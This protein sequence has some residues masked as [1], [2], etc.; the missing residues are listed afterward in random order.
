MIPYTP[1]IWFAC[2]VYGLPS[3]AI[4]FIVTKAWIE[5]MI[6]GT[7]VGLI[8]RRHE[9]KNFLELFKPDKPK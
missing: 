1:Y 9:I 4:A 3:A 8:L 7:I 6:S 5:V 2:L